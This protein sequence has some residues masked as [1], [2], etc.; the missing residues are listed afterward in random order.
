MKYAIRIMNGRCRALL[1]LGIIC[2]GASV[3]SQAVAQSNT[4]NCGSL[5][6]HFGPYDYTNRSHRSQHLALVEKHHF[7]DR[8]FQLK[9]AGD[10]GSMGLDID[11]TLRA[12]PNH[13]RALDAMSRLSIREGRPS[14]RHA[15]YTIDCYFERAMRWRPN[16]A[17][18]YLVRGIHLQRAGRLDDAIARLRQG[19][20]R[21]PNH[22]E[23][24][25][26]L[27]LFLAQKGDYA[28][29]RR[30]ARIAYRLGYPLPGLR[31]RLQ[32]AGEW[33]D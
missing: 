24:H 16:D 21:A 20:E 18:V 15:N 17:V 8:L 1:R 22:P 19:I 29:A 2:L 27:G 32:R 33:H 5:D 7:P 12:F 3:L 6:N 25:Y 14:P 23:I 9:G 13:H 10:G 11:Y 30:H 4:G 28:G 26:N 31:N